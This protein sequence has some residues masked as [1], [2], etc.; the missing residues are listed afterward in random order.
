MIF[1]SNCKNTSTKETTLF[2]WKKKEMEVCFLCAFP[3][4]YSLEKMFSLQLKGLF[5]LLFH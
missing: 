4:L 2:S 5:K 1:A 3:C